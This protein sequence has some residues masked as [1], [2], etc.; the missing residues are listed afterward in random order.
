MWSAVPLSSQENWDGIDDD[1]SEEE[2]RFPYSTPAWSGGDGMA[3]ARTVMTPARPAAA[4]SQSAEIRQW[5]RQNGWTV[6]SRGRLPEEVIEAYN[7]ANR[8]D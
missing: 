7:R 5:A 6:R 3:S 1:V 8:T 4:A 2:E